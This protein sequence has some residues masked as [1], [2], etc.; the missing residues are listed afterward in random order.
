VRCVLD[1]EVSYDQ[2]QQIYVF[3]NEFDLPANDGQFDAD[4]IFMTCNLSEDTIK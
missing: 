4:I 1:I 3:I 2:R